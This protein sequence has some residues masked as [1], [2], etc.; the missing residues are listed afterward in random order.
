MADNKYIIHQNDSIIWN[1]SDTKDPLFVLEEAAAKLLKYPLNTVKVYRAV[2]IKP[3]VVIEAANNA[4][5]SPAS[6]PASGA[7]T[8][9]VAASGSHSS[10]PGGADAVPGAGAVP[11]VG[12]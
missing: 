4:A 5:S 7:G 3:T 6:N 2:E 12:G 10:A 1:D 11:G 8:G 9:G